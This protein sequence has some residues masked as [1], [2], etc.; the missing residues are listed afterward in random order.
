LALPLTISSAFAAD[1][2]APTPPAPGQER[3]SEASSIVAPTGVADSESEP[4][5]RPASG[6]GT[7]NKYI[8]EK[9]TRQKFS[10]LYWSLGMLDIKDDESIDNF[11]QINECDIYKDYFYNEF[12][13]KNVRESGR[14]FLTE[15]K[16]KFPIRFE[17][18]QPLFLG[19]YNLQSKDFEIMPD[20]QIKETTRIEIFP[21]D[22]AD[23][24][25]QDDGSGKVSQIKNYPIGI[26]AEFNR[27][28]N[29]VSIPVAPDLAKYYIEEKMKYFKNLRSS[30]QT[31]ENL[32]NTRDAYIFMHIK[33]FAYK[34][35]YTN[36]DNYTMAEIMAVLEGFEVYADRDK[37]LLL[38][39]QDFRKKKAKPIRKPGDK[40][41]PVATEEPEAVKLDESTAEPAPEFSPQTPGMAVPPADPANVE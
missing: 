11:L 27:P 28:L 17:V 35:T 39:T 23:V 38:W 13:W 14:M 9:P 6:E 36:R 24:V 37:K 18:V 5:T 41:S 3:P 20:Y 2:A 16:N 22:F 26:V 12:E 34:D 10:R 25:C 15:N 40:K 33:F 29:L 7:E 31:Q 21:N 1:A 19:E 30:Q 4:T 32:Y 8:Y